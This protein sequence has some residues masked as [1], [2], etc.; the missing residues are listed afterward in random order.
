MAIVNGRLSIETASG[1]KPPSDWLEMHSDALIREILETVSLDAYC[2]ESYSTGFYGQHK[3]G[4]VTV[5]MVSL[6]SRSEAYVVFNADLKRVRGSKRG[7][8][9][10]KSQF[11]VGKRSHFYKFWLR[12]R[13]KVPDRLCHFH[14]YMGN[15]K[16]VL[17]SGNTKGERLDAGTL[18]PLG[19]RYES[20]ERL[21]VPPTIHPSPTQETP[22]SHP[23]LP[24]KDMPQ[25][26]EQK[27]F[28]PDRATRPPNC[29][30]KE[31]RETGARRGS[32]SS[33]NLQDQSVEEWIADYE[34]DSR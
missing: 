22:N 3:A 12:S 27:G 8:A 2:Y 34:E 31:I 24:P 17:F 26:L 29:G 16:G 7:S 19:V 14:D 32:Y 9:L 30:N 1:R 15:L 20:L 25:P 28:Q 13:L 18:S 10:P 21:I 4:G 6:L 5:Q 23:T 11:R 33:I